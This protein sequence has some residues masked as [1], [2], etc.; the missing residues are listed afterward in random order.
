MLPIWFGFWGWALHIT[1]VRQCLWPISL[2]PLRLTSQRPTKAE[3]SIFTASRT[4]WR[5]RNQTLL[6]QPFRGWEQSWER[7]H[8]GAVYWSFS[9]VPAGLE[10]ESLKFWSRNIF[11]TK[12]TA[13]P[14]HPPFP[15]LVKNMNTRSQQLHISNYRKMPFLL[16]LLISYFLY[17]F[18]LVLASSDSRCLLTWFDFSI[19][20][21]SVF[22]CV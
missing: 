17:L 19:S 20:L 6:G 14:T 5:Q 3:Q 10:E 2:A 4:R 7:E 12:I 22:V 1:D 11:F 15:L 8:C 18:I 9:R 21:P 16:S 13:K